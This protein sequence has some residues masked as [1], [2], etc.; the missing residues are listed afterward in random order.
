[1]RRGSSSEHAGPGCLWLWTREVALAELFIGLGWGQEKRAGTPQLATR[2]MHARGGAR[3]CELQLAP[4]CSGC[5]CVPHNPRS[6]P[7]T[8]SGTSWCSARS[9]RAA[10][11]QKRGRCATGAT[12]SPWRCQGSSL[13]KVSMG[14]RDERPVGV[15]L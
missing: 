1:M 2:G 6:A 12:T 4:L 13:H 9:Q 11:P 5:A 10:A 7:H 14:V 15:K 3:V 8:P